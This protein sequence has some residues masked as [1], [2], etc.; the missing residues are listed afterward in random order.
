MFFSKEMNRQRNVKHVLLG[1]TDVLKTCRKTT[2]SKKK[3]LKK[4]TSF[5][6]Q[7]VQG[8]FR[9]TFSLAL[10]SSAAFCLQNRV[11]D[12]FKFVLLGI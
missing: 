10:L 12:F 4:Y 1:K 6:E 2:H 3:N 5:E 8:I 11:S 7:K 9:E